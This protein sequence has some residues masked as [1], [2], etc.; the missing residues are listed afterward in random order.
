MT[1]FFFPIEVMNSSCSANNYDL[2]SLAITVN[3]SRSLIISRSYVRTYDKS[4][5]N[6][7]IAF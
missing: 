6:Y 7:A 2:R 3:S 1:S 4:S 5:F